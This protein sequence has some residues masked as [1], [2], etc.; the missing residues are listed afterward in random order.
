[1][2]RRRFIKALSLAGLSA[3]T[4]MALPHGS[5]AAEPPGG[6]KEF[7]GPYWIM[8]NCMGGWDVTHFCDPRGHEDSAGKG[9]INKHFSRKEIENVGTKSKPLLVGPDIIADSSGRPVPGHYYK[10]FFSTYKDRI[11][12]VNGVDCGTNGHSQGIRVTWS[13]VLTKGNPSIASMIA[14]E[15]MVDHNLP[16]PFLTFGGFSQ[17]GNMVVPTRL[18]NM[19]AFAK[20]VKPI[21][22]QLGKR[23]MD[24]VAEALVQKAAAARLDVLKGHAQLPRQGDGLSKLFTARAS[25][26]N[27]EKIMEHLD[28]K[29]LD[30]LP[31]HLKQVYITTAAFKAGIAVSANIAL[32]GWDTHSENF[33]N[34]GQNFVELFDVLH[35]IRQW[36]EGHGIG[37]KVHIFVGS[38][39]GRT[40]SF[41]GSRGKDHWSVGSWMHVSANPSGGQGTI[42]ATD[43]TM[44][45]KKID[46]TGSG[47]R[48]RHRP[49]PLCHPQRHPPACRHPR[50]PL[51]QTIPPG[52]GRKDHRFPLRLKP[53]APPPPPSPRSARRSLLP[54]GRLHR[55]PYTPCIRARCRRG[56]TSCPIGR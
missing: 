12:F 43:S 14:A 7:Q 26:Q 33:I 2:Q 4:P 35:K 34:T 16:M 24:P 11:T 42:G 52:R 53:H 10:D 19:A 50:Q 51:C 30:R 41:N 56:S 32:R 38:D 21:E 31:K 13:G 36:S 6:F 8:V 18:E 25:E 15:H 46:M 54:P 55:P 49:N 40:P 22:L 48:Q 37:D 20:V 39:F 17:T 44:L 45:G 5:R 9:P 27:I 1:M 47:C 3:F 29:E 23:F 28:L